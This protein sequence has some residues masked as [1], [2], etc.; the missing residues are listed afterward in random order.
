MAAR[1]FGH[2]TGVKALNTMRDA[3]PDPMPEARVALLP[4][5]HGRDKPPRMADF[6]GF[7][8]Q[9]KQYNFTSF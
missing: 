7:R 2:G 4:T 6:L 9:V 8:R 5:R 1:P 3:M